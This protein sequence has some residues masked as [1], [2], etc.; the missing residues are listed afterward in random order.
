MT[1]RVRIKNTRGTWSAQVEGETLP[2]IHTTWRD[3]PTGY[4]DPM[5][6]VDLDGKR[7]RDFVELLRRSDCAVLQRDTAGDPVARDAPVARDGY[8]GV[9]SYRDLHVA[10]D[11]AVTLELTARVGEPRR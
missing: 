2:V 8:V 9:F 7:Y 10:E 6:G 11:G 4:R 1:A 3:G 5:T